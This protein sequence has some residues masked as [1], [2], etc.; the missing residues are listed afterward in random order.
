M[1]P[2]LCRS[3]LRKAYG[4]PVPFEFGR[5][6]DF[7]VRRSGALKSP[8]RSPVHSTSVYLYCFAIILH[9]Y[10]SLRAPGDD[11]SQFGSATLCVSTD[12]LASPRA[13]PESNRSACLHVWSRARRRILELR[14]VGKYSFSKFPGL[15]AT[16]KLLVRHGPER[17]ESAAFRREQTLCKCA[18]AVRISLCLSLLLLWWL[19]YFLFVEQELRSKLNPRSCFP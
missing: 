14:C 19:S 3:T 15:A 11:S 1:S 6:V 18:P 16:R 2:R 9:H 4:F 8:P 5:S 13:S 17:Q 10:S 12:K 7:Q